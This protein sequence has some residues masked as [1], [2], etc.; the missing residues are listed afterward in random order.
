MKECKCKLCLT[1][2]PE[3]SKYALCDKCWSLWE[4]H[5]YPLI[6]DLPPVE[7]N[8]IIKPYKKRLNFWK[9]VNDGTYEKLVEQQ[10]QI[11]RD[12]QKARYWLDVEESRRKDREYARWYRSVNREK[13]REYQKKYREKRKGVKNV[14]TENV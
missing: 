9:L 5:V 11:R 1:K 6:K 10:K 13:I 8:K 2:L 4:K 14:G 7:W 12:R 3:D